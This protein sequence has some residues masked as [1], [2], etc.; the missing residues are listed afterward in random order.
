MVAIQAPFKASVDSHQ[1]VPVSSGWGERD[2][3]FKQGAPEKTLA[4]GYDVSGFHR[5]DRFS[6]EP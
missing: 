6:S 2:S 5:M 3:L 4:G 1:D